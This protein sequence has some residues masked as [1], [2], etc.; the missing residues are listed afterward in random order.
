MVDAQVDGRY[1]VTGRPSGALPFHDGGLPAPQA[2]GG[3]EEGLPVGPGG[4][5][6]RVE[7]STSAQRREVLPH[8]RRDAVHDLGARAHRGVDVGQPEHAEPGAELGHRGAIARHARIL[9][10]P[11]ARPQLCTP[12]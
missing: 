11:V 4:V 8:L 2:V 6:L 9:A 3:G 1:L 12:D 7:G 5:E 10:R